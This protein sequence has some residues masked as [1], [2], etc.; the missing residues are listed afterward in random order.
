MYQVFLFGMAKTI[1][2]FKAKISVI[3]PVFY[4]L[5]RASE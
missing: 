5:R 1:S 4:L 2:E 3:R